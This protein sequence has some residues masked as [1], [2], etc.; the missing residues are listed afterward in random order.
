MN[1]SDEGLD[2]PADDLSDVDDEL[3]ESYCVMNTKDVF[4][5]VSALEMDVRRGVRTVRYAVID[6]D[7]QNG[8]A[9]QA[10]KHLG[11]C[12]RLAYKLGREWAIANCA[13]YAK[14]ALQDRRHAVARKRR[15]ARIAKRIQQREDNDVSDG[16]DVWYQAFA[17]ALHQDS[18]CESS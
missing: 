8:L 14:L 16:S 17:S 7:T 12:S 11:D 2:V 13:T 3:F 18:P 1:G 10:Y 9:L 4:R 5:A 6:S 15:D